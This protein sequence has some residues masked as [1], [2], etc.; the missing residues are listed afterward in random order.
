MKSFL[1][2]Y[3]HYDNNG[4]K[5]GHSVLELGGTYFHYDN[6]GKCTGT[7][8]LILQNLSKGTKQLDEVM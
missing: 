7:S 6:N 3:I 8:T 2:D 4:N 1:N 5:I